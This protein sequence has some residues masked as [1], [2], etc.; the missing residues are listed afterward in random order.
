ML[1]GVFIKHISQHIK[2]I[3]LPDIM[4]I[5]FFKYAVFIAISIF[6]IIAILALNQ[7]ESVIFS[8]NQ[9]NNVNFFL[10]R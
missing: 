9:S 2:I 4:H 3:F 5:H 1:N 6:Q 10:I 7:F 8:V